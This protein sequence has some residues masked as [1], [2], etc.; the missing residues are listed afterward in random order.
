MEVEWKECFDLYDKDLCMGCR[1]SSWFPVW[2]GS[3]AVMGCDRP[4]DSDGKIKATDTD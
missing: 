3:D 2:W 1:R 4:Q